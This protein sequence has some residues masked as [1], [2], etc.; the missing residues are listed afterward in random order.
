M[1]NAVIAW[2]SMCSRFTSEQGDMPPLKEPIEEVTKTLYYRNFRHEFW[3][4]RRAKIEG[5]PDTKV[6]EDQKADCGNGGLSSKR[7]AGQNVAY[8]HSDLYYLNTDLP[9]RVKLAR[10]SFLLGGIDS[11]GPGEPTHG[12]TDRSYHEVKRL[13]EEIEKAHNNPFAGLKTEKGISDAAS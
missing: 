2:I 7:I 1:R 10:A 6:L 12:R 13:A 8:N 9:R 5:K 4:M 11:A 3:R